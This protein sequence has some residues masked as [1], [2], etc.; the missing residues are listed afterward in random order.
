[1]GVIRIYDL[2]SGQFLTDCR[3]HSSSILSLKFSPDGK[4]IVSTGQ[5]GLVAI[6][7]VFI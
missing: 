7:N 6:W 4:Q 3:A 5:D 1:M 2:E